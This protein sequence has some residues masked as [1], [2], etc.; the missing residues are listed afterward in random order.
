MAYTPIR[1]ITAAE[2]ETFQTDGVVCLRGFFDAETVRTLQDMAEENTRNPSPMAVDATR[3]GKGR[4]FGD[5]F[6]WDHHPPLRQFI[7]DSPAA[8]MAGRILQSDKVNVIFDQFLIKEPGTSTPTLWHHDQTYWPV[9]GDQVATM[10][11]ALDPVTAAT[12]AVE[13]IKGSHRWGQRFKAVSFKD[14]DLYKEDLP[15]VP[16]IDANRDRY[17]FVQYELEPGD[18]T[19]HHG[20]TLHGAPGNSSTTQKRRAYIIRWAGDD[21][22]YDPRPNLQPM[23]RDP[24]IAVGGPLDCDLFPVVRAG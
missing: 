11:I 12:G 8:D 6:V 20:L 2:I 21:V 18:C 7:F 24:G 15:E 5:T 10:W 9:A 22:T 16:D 14:Q 1:D 3:E 19:L 23:L 4:F 17:D 13:Y